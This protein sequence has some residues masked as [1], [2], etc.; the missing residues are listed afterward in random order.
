[1]NQATINRKIAASAIV[2][3]VWFAV[4]YLAMSS[5]RP[6]YRHLTKAISELGSLD[7]PNAWIWNVC[8]YIIPGLVIAA[9][10]WGVRSRFAHESGAALPSWALIASGL[11]I[12]LSGVFPGDFE[13]RTS[14]TMILHA[15]G[16]IGS[17]VAFL[18]SAFMLPR[19]MRRHPGW[20]RCVWPS[21]TVAVASICTGFLRTGDAPGLGQRLGFACVFLW[22][23][24]IG[25]ALYRDPT[26]VGAK[27]A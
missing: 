14:T 17:F 18:V 20:S 8:G 2:V 5:A 22:V 24:L 27:Q 3:P 21:L 9:L 4:T 13:D 10:G 26:P 12:A 15:V 16:S 6:E 1:M 19:V 11:C 23:A 25:Y 7:A